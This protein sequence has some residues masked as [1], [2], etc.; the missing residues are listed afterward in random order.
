MKKRITLI[1]L[2]LII[3]STLFGQK[4][5]LTDLTNVCNKKNWQDVNQFML[6]KGWTY[7]DSQK[8]DTDN[9][10]TITW[11]YNKESYSDKAQGW[12][13]LYT[14]DDFPNKV[15]Y[16]I[17]NKASYLLIQNSLTTS[18]F[19][20]IDSEI[21]DEK[22][23]STYANS[24]YILKIS[25]AKRSDDDWSDRSITSYNVTLIKKSG[26]YDFDNGKK[27]EYYDDYTIKSEYNLLNGK[28][29]GPVKYYHENGNLKKIVNFTND[30]MNGKVVEYNEN[31]IKDS[32]YNS[33]MGKANGLCTNYYYNDETEKLFLKEIGSFVNDEKNGTWT[34]YY[35]NDKVEKPLTYTNYLKDSKEGQ[36]QEIEGDSLIIGHYKNNE[37]DGGYKVYFDATRSIVG[38][39]INTNI[40]DLTLI[41]E[42]EYK[43]GAKTGYWKNYTITGSL[44]EEGNY[45]DNLENG[46]WNYYYPNYVKQNGEAEPFAKQLVLKSTFLNGILNGKTERFYYQE[47]IKYPCDEVDEHGVKVD[48]CFKLKFHKIHET[49][50]Y[51]DGQLHGFYEAK[52]SINQ[53]VTK[54]QYE[55]GLKTG[56]WVSYSN[57]NTRDKE[58]SYKSGMI[59]GQYILYNENNQPFAIKQFENNLL[60]MSTVYT[61]EGQKKNFQ[62]EILARENDHFKVKKTKYF[63]EKFY[64][65]EYW[66]KSIKD[67]IAFDYTFLP[68]TNDDKET[69]EIYTDG[70]YLLSTI[71]NEPLV[72]GTL[73]K[74]K[75]R[76]TWTNYYYDQK[77]KIENKYSNNEVVEELYLKLDGSLFSGEFENI[78]IEKNIKEV[79]KIKDGL[80][81]GKTTFVNLETNK[82]INKENYKEGKLKE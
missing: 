76:D 16:N 11:S 19:K 45:I 37:L 56:T 79:R 51:K 47:D 34:T 9:Y 66:V 31:G 24:G 62:V 22:V 50:Y 74:G 54:G 6:V 41:S 38:G 82:T 40:P 72:E 3:S 39:V 48:S 12:F 60:K 55:D 4:L 25:N 23:I 70:N 2:T 1:L 59:N 63:D 10:N 42:G 33:I 5:S 80:R 81:N 7:Y 49:S 13:Y 18:G 26:I 73:F 52:D 27:T 20:L 15:S 64:S 78:D 68:M 17:F 69:D 8:G 30:E 57:G 58:I 53:L 35:I 71:N 65:K 28:L 29:N 67:E 61:D 77:V 43:N 46:N 32:E 44:S 36:F 75:K 21:E 14:Y